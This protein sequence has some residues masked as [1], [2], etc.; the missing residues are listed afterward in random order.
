MEEI[1]AEGINE[2]L[3]TMGPNFPET[4]GPPVASQ[5]TAPLG[6]SELHEPSR[7]ELVPCTNEGNFN[8]AQLH[9]PA[10]PDP[11]LNLNL[12]FE[13]A[14]SINGN[15]ALFFNANNRKPPG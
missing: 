13:F 4:P 12:G 2:N 14:Q 5:L 8:L 7:G 15:A 1:S 3:F 9:D 11:L 6:P 10:P